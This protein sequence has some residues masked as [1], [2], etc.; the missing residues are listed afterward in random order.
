ML[1]KYIPVVELFTSNNLWHP[2]IRLRR[3]STPCGRCCR[4]KSATRRSWSVNWDSAPWPSSNRTSLKAGRTSRPQ[5]RKDA[6]LLHVLLTQTQ[7]VTVHLSG[8]SYAKSNPKPP[9]Q[10]LKDWQWFDIIL[11]K[12]SNKKGLLKWQLGNDSVWWQVL[13]SGG[14]YLFELIHPQFALL[15]LTHIPLALRCWKSA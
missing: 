5:T 9:S 6:F 14:I 13:S 3:R 7:E 1:K 4:L 12:I 15:Q 11:D 2:H 10:T 8:M